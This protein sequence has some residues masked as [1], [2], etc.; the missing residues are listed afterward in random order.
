MS[1][2]RTVYKLITGE[3]REKKLFMAIF[4]RDP[5]KADAVIKR[6]AEKGPQTGGKIIGEWADIAGGRS[7]RVIEHNDPKVMLAG[8]VAWSD[9]GKTEQERSDGSH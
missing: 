2:P 8:V 5:E 7:F 6:Q 4:T 9:L 3:R 1:G